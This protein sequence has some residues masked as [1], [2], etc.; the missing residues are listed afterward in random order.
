MQHMGLMNIVRNHNN[1][2]GV[3]PENPAQ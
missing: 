2:M 1:Q 3:D